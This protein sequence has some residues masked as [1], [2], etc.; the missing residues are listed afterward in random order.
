MADNENRSLIPLPGSALVKQTPGA[1]R[2]LSRNGGGITRARPAAADQR[3]GS[4]VQDR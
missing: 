2:V 3:P 4:K 1:D